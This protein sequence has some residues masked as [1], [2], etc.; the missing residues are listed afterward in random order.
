MHSRMSLI[1]FLVG[2]FTDNMDQLLLVNNTFLSL[3]LLAFRG[4]CDVLDTFPGQDGYGIFLTSLTVFCTGSQRLNV[5]LWRFRCHWC[6]CTTTE[7]CR[8]LPCCP[9]QGDRTVDM[10]QG[11]QMRTLAQQYLW[12]TARHRKGMEM[13]PSVVKMPSLMGW[14]S[15]WQGCG[16]TLTFSVMA[17]QSALAPCSR[18]GWFFLLCHHSEKIS[19]SSYKQAGFYLAIQ[20]LV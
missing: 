14:L 11:A 8:A 12:K 1:L 3:D 19:H 17:V 16:H 13:M 5:M 7:H 2:G 4:F 9:T 15:T 20:V 10:L 18:A 6:L